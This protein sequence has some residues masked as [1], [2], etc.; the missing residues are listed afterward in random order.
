MLPDAIGAVP[1]RPEPEQRLKK[2]LIPI[3]RNRVRVPDRHQSFGVST[4]QI[5]TWPKEKFKNTRAWKII[6]HQKGHTSN[7]DIQ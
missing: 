7:L 1:V 2:F 5:S 6:Y 4:Q 3:R